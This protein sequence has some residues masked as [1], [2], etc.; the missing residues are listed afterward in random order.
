MFNE[1]LSSLCAPC[2]VCGLRACLGCKEP[3]PDDERKTQVHKITLYIVDHD[4][5]GADE[6]AEVLENARY[7]NRCIIPRGVVVDGT[8]EV[9]WS[10]SHPINR[11]STERSALAELF[12]NDDLLDDSPG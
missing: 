5:L 4:H 9:N 6:C 10:D 3:M 12:S 2:R 11:L 7:T 1:R 8:R